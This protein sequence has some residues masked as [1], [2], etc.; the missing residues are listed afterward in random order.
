MEVFLEQLLLVKDR[1]TRAFVDH[2]GTAETS[3]VS[4]LVFATSRREW[5]KLPQQLR[6]GLG[7]WGGL[8]VS[9]TH[10]HGTTEPLTRWEEQHDTSGA[11][12]IS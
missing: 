1:L 4:L 7:F 8:C 5:E 6:K 12:K 3:Q 2:P 11:L 9:S 10:T